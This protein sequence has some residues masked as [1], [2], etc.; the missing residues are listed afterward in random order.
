[1]A[2]LYFRYGA[3]NGGKTTILLQAAHNYEEQGMHVFL[4]KP[5]IDSKGDDKLVSRL[6]I[7]RKVDYV[8][9]PED[10]L[11]EVIKTNHEAQKISCVLAD[12]AQFFTPDQADQLMKVTVKLRIPVICYGLRTDFLGNG[13]AGSTR[14]LQIAHTIEEIKTI[15]R[16]GK[17]AIYNARI[18][19]GHFVF[20]G[21]QVAIDGTDNVSYESLCADCYFRERELADID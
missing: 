7:S 1:M 20:S 10:N 4:V 12:E 15:C 16:C 6:G 2:K 11:F 8:C 17:K 13:F 5:S 3:M 14:L 21:S 19:N 9:S 18:I